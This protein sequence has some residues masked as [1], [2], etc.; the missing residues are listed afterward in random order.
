MTCSLRK[1]TK[2]IIPASAGDRENNMRKEITVLKTEQYIL[3]VYDIS[4]TNGFVG[5]TTYFRNKR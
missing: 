1:T 5:I 3:R 2:T 4:N